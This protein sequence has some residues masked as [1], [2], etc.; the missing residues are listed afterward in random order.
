MTDSADYW[1]A[2]AELWHANYVEA[3]K[4]ADNLETFIEYLTELL[5]SMKVENAD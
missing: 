4:R 1:K 2:Q 3:Q 5:L